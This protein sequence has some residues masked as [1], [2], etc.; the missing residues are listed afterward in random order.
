MKRAAL[1]AALWVA[2]VRTAM[3]APAITVYTTS[4][5]PVA[6]D[7]VPNVTVYWLDEPEQPLSALSVGLPATVEEAAPV[8]LSRMNTPGGKRLMGDLKRAYQ[9]VVN[10][11]LNNVSQL[12]AI[13]I[14]DRYVLYGVYDVNEALTIFENHQA[15]RG[16]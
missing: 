15:R 9:G 11:W 14:D 16:R 4:F 7:N 10:A 2:M 6:H 8:V 3:A 12:P 1:I 5:L 13:L